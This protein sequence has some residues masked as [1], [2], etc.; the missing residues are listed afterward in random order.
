MP[1]Q[2]VK[3][4]FKTESHS[5][6]FLLL[7]SLVALFLANS[8]LKTF[9]NQTINWILG[10]VPIHFWVNEVLMTFFF[11]MV[12]LEIKRQLLRSESN[13][14][15][16]TFLL[17]VLAAILG[18]ICPGVIY[19]FF[20]HGHPAAMRGWAVPIATDIVFSLM[21]LSF[22]GS[23][24]PLSL[25]TF[26][27]SVAIF[28]DLG[29]I[30]VI[31]L[32]YAEKVVG[33][34]L[35]I[36]LGAVLGLFFLKQWG[37]RQIAPYVILGIALWLC[38]FKAGVHPTLAGVVWAFMIPLGE[39]PEEQVVWGQLETKLQPWVNFG[40]LPLFGFF[41]AG[42]PLG[43]AMHKA[44]WSN[45]IVLGTAGGLFIG[46]QLGIFSAIWSAKR[47]G[48]IRQIP[49]GNWSASYAVSLFCGIG[50][51]MSLFIGDLA[52]SNNPVFLDNM[53]VGVMLGS[54]ASGIAGYMLLHYLVRVSKSK[55]N[56]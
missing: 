49:G 31:A 29:A 45:S 7:A 21:V 56:V 50:F 32:F 39:K 36:A 38:V 53:R 19:W 41:N 11:L 33:G 3:K 13:Q 23:R 35:L 27:I 40:V 10:G 14:G 17:P 48:M 6:F 37:V 34:F 1:F 2:Q 24:I 47:W 25:K 46:K 16:G 22:G 43:I 42:V 51:T 52:F 20:N 18:M 26:L 5:G 30:L 8:G 15:S 28:D 9:Y 44:F 54:V 12:S 4:F 55:R